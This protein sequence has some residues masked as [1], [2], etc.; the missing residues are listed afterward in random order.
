MDLGRSGKI[1]QHVRKR[2]QTVSHKRVTLREKH[3]QE[4]ALILHQLVVVMTAEDVKMMSIFATRKSPVVNF[5]YF[6]IFSS[7]T[8]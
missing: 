1:G 8:K 3:D 7:D 6:I 2:V 5:I 4:L